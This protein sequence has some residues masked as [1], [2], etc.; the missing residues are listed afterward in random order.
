MNP[1]M[2]SSKSKASPTRAKDSSHKVSVAKNPSRNGT[3]AKNPSRNGT[4]AKAPAGNVAAPLDSLHPGEILKTSLQSNSSEK[5]ESPDLFQY[6][7]Y[8]LFIKDFF[9]AKKRKN[10]S[11][12]ASLFVRRAGLG[13]NSRGYLKLIIDGKR[14]LTSHTI[15]SFSEAMDLTNA[16]SL[17]FENLVFFNQAEKPKDR[18]YYFER[19]ESCSQGKHSKPIELLQ[20]QLSLVSNW[21]VLAIRELIALPEFNE[22]PAWIS[23]NLRGKVT[24]DEVK[25][26]IKALLSVGLIKRD[27]KTDRLIQSESTFKII[28]GVFNEFLQNYH[29]QMMDRAREAIQEDPYAERHASGLIFSVPKRV[30]PEIIQSI[31]QFRDQMR[32]KF[33]SLKEIP[34]SVIH[35][36]IQAFQLTP[37]EK[38]TENKAEK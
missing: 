9:E 12:S 8:R 23:K 20:S 29:L 4:D 25:S 7:D 18:K 6:V 16:Q 31:N 27:E 15:R 36:N 1:L 26:A 35:V 22:E 5:P 33:G 19:L 10:A 21:Y 28:G 37:I 11:Y 3:D 13:E 30:L 14:N 2:E 32:E 34:D 38:K 24:R 17:Y